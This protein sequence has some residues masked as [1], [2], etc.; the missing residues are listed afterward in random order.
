MI[1]L[2]TDPDDRPRSTELC[3]SRSEPKVIRIENS[4]PVAQNLEMELDRSG[5]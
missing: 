1:C 3:E 5:I 4:A 2:A